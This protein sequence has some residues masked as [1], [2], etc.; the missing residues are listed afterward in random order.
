MVNF[1]STRKGTT[2]KYLKLQAHQMQCLYFYAAECFFELLWI[3]QR[4]FDEEKTIKKSRNYMSVFLSPFLTTR[5][6]AR[7]RKKK[8]VKLVRPLTNR[9]RRE[10]DSFSGRWFYASM[11]LFDYVVNSV[12]L[13]QYIMS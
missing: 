12:C 10:T 2:W 7:N 9:T 11:F 5:F 13:Q 6:C 4:A 1:C 3:I 8:I